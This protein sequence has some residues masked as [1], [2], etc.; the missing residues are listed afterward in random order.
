M[1]RQIV[2]CL[3]PGAPLFCIAS[4]L[5]VLRHANR[6]AASEIYQWTFLCEDNQPIQ[7]GNGLW[8]YPGRN[9][10]EIDPPY[11]AFI[12]AGFDASQLKQP[13]LCAWLTKQAH[14]NRKIG[15]ISN[16]AF[17]LAASGLLNHYSATTH[18]ED[19]ESFCL[20]F[21]QVQPRY[22]R[23]VIDRN[24]LTCAGGS[25]TLDMFIELV[26]QDLGNEI[27]LKISRQMLLQEQ[28]V[29]LP[30][31]PSSRVTGRQY[32]P[33]VQRALGMIEAGVGQSITVA[34]LASR[35]GI[36]RRELLRLFRSELNNTP[37]NILGQRRLDRARSLILNTRL[38]M[39]TIADS[40]GFS[41]QSHLTSSYHAQFG[42]TPAQQ[43]REYRAASHRLP[44]KS[45]DFRDW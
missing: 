23:F 37:S 15:A 38:P 44:L 31:S 3:C 7:D 35:I 5:D 2:F 42:I 8:L 11:L 33:R 4:A 26:R 1:N 12:V 17:L 32:S 9:I 41:S 40:V 36:S 14:D 10:E 19:F 39:A 16:G 27:V 43:R 24:R 29:V 25:A 22:Q 21:P 28:S 18:W 6:F 13:Q 45:R 30:G 20:L 34:D